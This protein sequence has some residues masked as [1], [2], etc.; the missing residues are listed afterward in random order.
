MSTGTDGLEYYPLPDGTYGV[1]MG[2]T[3][4]LETVEIPATYLGKAVTKILDGAFQNAV[5]LKNI[6]IP[7][8]VTDIGE[9]AFSHCNGLASVSIGKGV[10]TIGDN[11]F[12]GCE[13]LESVTVS[14]SVTNI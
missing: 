3:K 11:A 4:Y 8:S 13:N 1:K 9:Y 6:S 12:S 2:T 10:T 5:N 7:D 14:D